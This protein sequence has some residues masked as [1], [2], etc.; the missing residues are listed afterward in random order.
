M[1]TLW[2]SEITRAQ[3]QQSIS[4]FRQLDE[5]PDIPREN[6][7]NLE[8]NSTRQ[9]SVTREKEIACNLAFLSATSDDS[10]KV[11][12]ACVEERCNRKGIIIRVAANTGDLS[13]ATAGFVRLAGVLEYAALRVRSKS[14][15]TK[16]AFREVVS[17]D[18]DRILSRPRSRYAR[19]TRKTAGK[20]PPSNNCMMRFTV[21]RSERQR[22]LRKA[23]VGY[24][25]CK[26]YL[27]VLRA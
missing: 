17:L 24:E 26:A 3:L 22:H 27:L 4:N 23:G 5:L 14:E 12:A 8:I 2:G 16:E 21:D 9:L 25:I 7:V 18:F 10:L 20:R 15:D 1:G 11:M 19:I 6:L 13:T